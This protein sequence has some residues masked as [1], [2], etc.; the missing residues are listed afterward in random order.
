MWP[1]PHSLRWLEGALDLHNRQIRTRRLLLPRQAR[2]DL[3]FSP[4]QMLDLHRTQQHRRNLHQPGQ[5]GEV[6]GRHSYQMLD[7]RN[8]PEVEPQVQETPRNH[9]ARQEQCRSRV[10]VLVL[11]ILTLGHRR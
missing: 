8:F 1:D 10:L 6:P 2:L 5:Q 4:H 3:A 7:R 11:E 9:L